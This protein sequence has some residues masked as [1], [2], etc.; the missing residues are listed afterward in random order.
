MLGLALGLSERT[1]GVEHTQLL[2]NQL[3]LPHCLDQRSHIH[4]GSQPTRDTKHRRYKESP[5]GQPGINNPITTQPQFH[6]HEWPRTQI[7]RNQA[8][9]RAESHARTCCQ[10]ELALLH[11]Q[12]RKTRTILCD[13]H[14]NSLTLTQ[15]KD[16]TKITLPVTIAWP[17]L[18]QNYMSCFVTLV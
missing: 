3:N 15:T 13:T 17:T 1:R 7:L 5:L 18:L 8:F 12:G 14:S 16:H 11:V 2:Y 9:V 6:R 10:K 4:D